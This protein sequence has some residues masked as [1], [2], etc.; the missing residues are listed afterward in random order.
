ME[1]ENIRNKAEAFLA[2]CERLRHKYFVTLCIVCPIGKY[3]STMSKLDY[4]F[5]KQCAIVATGIMMAL[6]KKINFPCIPL[7][8]LVSSVAR[9]PALNSWSKLQEHREEYLW[10]EDGTPTRELLKRIG[11][12]IDDVIVVHAKSIRNSGRYHQYLSQITSQQTKRHHYRYSDSV[13]PV[14]SIGNA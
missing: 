1:N 7:A 3:Q 10:N 2:E 5:D 6:C 12:V 4:L 13:L 9:F 11:R 8:G 14:L